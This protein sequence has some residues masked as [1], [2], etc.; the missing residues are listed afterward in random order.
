MDL[1][2]VGTVDFFFVTKLSILG[3]ITMSMTLMFLVFPTKLC[4]SKF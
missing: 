2:V 3:K 1:E 4:N